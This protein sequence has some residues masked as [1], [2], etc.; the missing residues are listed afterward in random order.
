MRSI[1]LTLALILGII[2]SLFFLFRSCGEKNTQIASLKHTNDSLYTLTNQLGQKVTSQ[3]VEIVESKELLKEYTDSIFKLQKKHEKNIAA[4]TAYW[5]SRVEVKVIEVKVPYL[6]TPTMR[7]FSDSIRLLCKDVFKYMEDSMIVVPR[8]AGID[9]AGL[10]ADFTVEKNGVKISKLS[11]IDTMH[12]RVVEVKGGFFKR[13]ELGSKKI[14]FYKKKTYEVQTMHTSPLF[15]TTWQKSYLYVPPKK[16]IIPK[17]I[18]PAVG[19]FF[20]LKAI[21]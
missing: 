3:E 14:K 18:L 1:N 5:K 11:I 15:N 12:T 20:L 6:D 2:I 8:E 16:Y 7:K 4:V 17:L 9:S 10:S 21:L 13:D 19:L